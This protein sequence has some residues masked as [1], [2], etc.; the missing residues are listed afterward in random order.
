LVAFLVA[1]FAAYDV[2]FFVAFLVVVLW[3]YGAELSE[4]V[5][6]VDVDI[7]GTLLD[8]K[9]CP[10]LFFGCWYSII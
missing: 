4:V 10:W 9:F 6:G 3:D 8:V 5:D 1:F 2:A 7:V